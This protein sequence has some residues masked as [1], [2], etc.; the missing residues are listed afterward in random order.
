[1]YIAPYGV[2][3]WIRAATEGI[4]MTTKKELVEENLQLKHQIDLMEGWEIYKQNVFLRMKV[5]SLKQKLFE[6]AVSSN[7]CMVGLCPPSGGQ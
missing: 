2:G 6:Q 1:M 7:D 4:E 5:L 3:K